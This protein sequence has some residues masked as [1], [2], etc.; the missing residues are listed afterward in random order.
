[1]Y[2]WVDPDTGTTQLSGK[3]PVWYRSAQGGPRV[4]VFENGKVIDDTGL[5]VSGG[6]QERLRQ[7]AFLQ[8]ED[9]KAAAKEKLLEGKKLEA[10]LGLTDADAQ[11]VEVIT[12][13]EPA[14]AP[15]EKEAQSEEEE[16]INQMRSLIEEWESRRTENARELVNPN[17]DP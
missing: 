1:M 15:P 6:E 2:Q 3:P 7:Q 5:A 9:D 14:S 13:P 10:A 8:A 12:E 4:F 16:T 11:E 17:V